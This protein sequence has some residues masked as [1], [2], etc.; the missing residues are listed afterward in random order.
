VR[1]LWIGRDK[2]GFLVATSAR[3]AKRCAS[4]KMRPYVPHETDEQRLRREVRE[5]ARGIRRAVANGHRS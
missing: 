4:A 3:E 5:L 2:I 1:T